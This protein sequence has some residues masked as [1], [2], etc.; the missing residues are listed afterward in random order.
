LDVSLELVEQS[1]RQTDGL[2][3]VVSTA[4]VFDFNANGHGA[5]FVDGGHE[6]CRSRRNAALR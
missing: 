2:R 3:L 4:A 6:S 5:S 1:R